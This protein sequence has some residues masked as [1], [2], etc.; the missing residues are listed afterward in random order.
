MKLLWQSLG[1]QREVGLSSCALL[2]R[3]LLLAYGAQE[4]LGLR[5]WGINRVRCIYPTCE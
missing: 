5:A 3:P 4:W 2:V 1:E